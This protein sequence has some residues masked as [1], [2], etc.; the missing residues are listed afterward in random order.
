MQSMVEGAWAPKNH[1]CWNEFYADAGVLTQRPPARRRS[2]PP[3]QAGE[4]PPSRSP[5]TIARP[6]GDWC[7]LRRLFHLCR[8]RERFAAGPGMLG[9][10]E[11]HAFGPV[12]LHF[13]PAD[14]LRL[15]LVHRSEEHTSELQSRF[16][17]SYAVFCL[18]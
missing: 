6:A 9:D 10:V 5:R 2:P 16:G 1:E 4:E 13:E 3:P 12:H 11:Q 18:K 15:A 7:L 8:G 17:I 14:P